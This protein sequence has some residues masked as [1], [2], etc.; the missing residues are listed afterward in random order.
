MPQVESC[1]IEKWT[2]WY[3]INIMSLHIMNIYEYHT[4]LH[5]CF[6]SH[7][8][9]LSPCAPVPGTS[10]A[11]TGGQRLWP[12]PGAACS[13]TSSAPPPAAPWASRWDPV[14]SRWGAI[15]MQHPKPTNSWRWRYRNLEMEE[16]LED[17]IN[18]QFFSSFTLIYS[19]F[20][21]PLHF[22]LHSSLPYPQR[23]IF[24]DWWY[25]FLY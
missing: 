19:F 16:E 6:L 20:E 7:E 2:N 8:A 4:V 23:H 12:G 10:E 18:V 14:A 24:T 22:T 5:W 25:E 11:W 9:H 15:G 3:I 17:Y 21:F 1:K 13:T